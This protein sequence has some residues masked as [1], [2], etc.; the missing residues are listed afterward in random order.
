MIIGT[1]LSFAGSW[2]GAYL[3]ESPAAAIGFLVGVLLLIA[4]GRYA[5]S[6]YQSSGQ[7]KSR[8]VPIS[9]RQPRRP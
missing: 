5:I 6:R 2:F 3:F 7:R 4:G 1:A 9:G 8:P